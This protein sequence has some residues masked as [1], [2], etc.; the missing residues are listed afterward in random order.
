MLENFHSFKYI[1]LRR[2]KTNFFAWSPFVL[3]LSRIKLKFIN[4]SYFMF[5]FFL[6]LVYEWIFICR[7]KNIFPS[8][9]YIILSKIFHSTL[10][11]KYF[12][13]EIFVTLNLTN[14]LDDD[15]DGTKSSNVRPI[16]SIPAYSH[17]SDRTALHRF[18]THNTLTLH[19]PA[20]V[21]TTYGTR[22][23]KKIDIWLSILWAI[24]DVGSKNNSRL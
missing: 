8:V 17:S 18:P 2:K 13:F 20:L 19:I 11:E 6:C 9:S 10:T 14:A 22:E 24:L 23:N 16:C 4:S 21:S 1:H 7:N 5:F 3:Y 15:Q 12:F